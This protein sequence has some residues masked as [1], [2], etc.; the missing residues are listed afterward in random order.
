MFLNFENVDPLIFLFPINKLIKGQMWVK[1]LLCQIL[2]LSIDFELIL[3]PQFKLS[4]SIESS[5]MMNHFIELLVSPFLQVVLLGL[6]S[7][8]CEFL[9]Q[10]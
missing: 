4:L 5:F 8:P 2:E 9:L 1:F 10:N 6:K 3:N 7:L